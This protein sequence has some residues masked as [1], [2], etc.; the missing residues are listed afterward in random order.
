[1]PANSVLDTRVLA[2]ALTP[3]P[4]SPAALCKQL[5]T[6]RATLHRKLTA[7]MNE[8]LV[9]QEGKGPTSTYRLKTL[10]EMQA[11]AMPAATGDKKVFI[12]MSEKTARVVHAALELY[13]RIG[14]GQFAEVVDM[15]RMGEF[16]RSDGTEITLEQLHTAE[17]DVNQLKQSLLGFSPNS[18]FGIYSPSVSAR[19]KEAWAVAKCLRHRLAW[20]QTP[21]GN[22]GV[23][24]DEPM[25]G[26]QI[27]GLAVH[28]GPPKPQDVDVS[29]LLPNTFL[30]FKGGK[31]RIIGPTADG[32]AFQLF[33][34]SNSWQTALMKAKKTA[35]KVAAEAKK[36]EGRPVPPEF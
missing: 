35:L 34:E 20:D 13:A 22:L 7:L 12:E 29:L 10:E 6:S 2:A 15:A 30:K 32:T 17:H 24:H 3:T 21:E 9:L 19:T 16:K 33:A 5:G 25:D 18:S 26:E 27:P 28:S 4:T 14:I 36:A 23:W 31:F 11:E 8:G 1:M